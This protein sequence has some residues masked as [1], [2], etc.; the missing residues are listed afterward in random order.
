[1]AATGRITVVT[2][3]ASGIGKCIALRLARGGAR[4][5]VFDV[6]L[7]GAEDTVGQIRAGGGESFAA[8]VDV[9]DGAAVAAGMS[10]VREE[11]G[12]VAVLVNNAGM[13]ELVPVAKMTEEQWDR[14]LAVH[15]KGMFLCARA[16]MGDMVQ[17]GW[18]RIVNMAS[19]A[20]MTG[21]QGF[22][23]YA[24]A[25]GGIIAFTKSL[26]QELGPRGVTV[27]AIAPG[28]IETAAIRRSG[29]PQSVIDGNLRA[30]AVKRLGQPE[31]IAAACAYLVSDE[32]GFVTGQVL[33]PNGGVHM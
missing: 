30:Q 25:K 23:H 27:N 4:V 15:L 18:G 28:L 22:A 9:S 2:G 8:E 11:F 31:D 21:S 26:A 12:P 32:A 14:M 16:A 10:R 3:G 6:D 7:A 1:M 24:A 20:G 33:S 17:A 19:V 13:G 5:A 29:L